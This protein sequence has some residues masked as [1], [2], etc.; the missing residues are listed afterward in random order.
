MDR[1]I[2]SAHWIPFLI[3]R[4]TRRLPRR[5]ARSRQTAGVED[6][7]RDYSKTSNFVPRRMRKT[8]PVLSCHR[9]Y[10]RG[11]A[12]GRQAARCASR[13]PGATRLAAFFPWRMAGSD[14]GSR[15]SAQSKQEHVMRKVI[16]GSAKDKNLNV[17]LIGTIPV[18]HS[19]DKCSPAA[20]QV[21]RYLVRQGATIFKKEII[22]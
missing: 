17:I 11:T 4:I 10:S 22:R 2:Q 18:P 8:R 9:P 20:R 13:G 3:A 15:Y 14:F 6:T 7:S 12:V 5:I 16:R 1:S 19:K 21:K